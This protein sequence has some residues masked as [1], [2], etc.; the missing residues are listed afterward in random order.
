MARLRYDNALGLLGAGLAVD[1]GPDTIT[2][3]AVPPFATLGGDDYIPLVLNPP[4]GNAPSSSFEVVYLTAYTAGQTTGTISRA[5]EGTAAKVHSAG[6]LWVCGPTFRDHVFKNTSSKTFTGLTQGT[7]VTS[8]ITAPGRACLLY[9][10][11]ADQPCRF[12]L[13]ATQAQANADLGRSQT[14]DPTGNHGCLLEMVITTALAGAAFNLAPEVTA[15]DQDSP[16]SS[17]FSCNVRCDN[18]GTLNVSL[19]G[20]VVEP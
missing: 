3:G 17:T 5:Q 9:Q 19:A 10:F 20:M 11:Q 14:V 18:G 16:S 1:A 7:E 4:L 2:F 13:Y 6:D 15:R 8:T 12:R